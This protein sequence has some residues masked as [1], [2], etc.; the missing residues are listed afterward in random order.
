MA[1]DP[2]LYRI[3]RFAP[4]ASPDPGPRASLAIAGV[5]GGAGT[6]IWLNHASLL[7]KRPFYATSPLEFAPVS[8][9]AKRESALNFGLYAQVLRRSCIATEQLLYT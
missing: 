3:A 2:R 1:C 4:S 9:S 6:P 7:R 5:R 8:S